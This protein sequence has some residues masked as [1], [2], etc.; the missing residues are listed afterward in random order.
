MDNW[1]YAVIT[2]SPLNI[3]WVYFANFRRW[4]FTSFGKM[5]TFD[6]VTFNKKNIDGSHD[7]VGWSK[8][9]DWLKTNRKLSNCDG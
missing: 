9:G 1:L 6:L 2:V 5:G 3:L 4:V 7:A 8:Q